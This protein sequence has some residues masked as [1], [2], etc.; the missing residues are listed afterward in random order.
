[1]LAS[2]LEYPPLEQAILP[3]DLVV[4]AVDSAAAGGAAMVAAVWRVL[5]RRGVPPQ[6]V[7]ILESRAA[8][9]AAPSD[10]RVELPPEARGRIAWKVHDPDREDDRVY[11][12]STAAG[13]RIYLNRTLVDADVV[14]SLGQIA[15]D[16]LIGVAGTNSVFYPGM[17][18]REAVQRAQG[19][20]HDELG[21]NEDRPLRQVMDEIGWLL[22]SQFTVQTIPAAGRGVSRVLA[23]SPESVLRR[24][25][26]LLAEHWLIELKS[27]PDIVIAAVDADAGGHGWE[28]AGA[29]LAVARNLVARGGQI[30]LLTE[31]AA[32]P[33]P[34][35][36]MLREV[37]HPRDALRP[38]QSSHPADLVPAMQFAAAADRAKIYFLSRLEP[39]LVDEL[40]MTPLDSAQQ[41]ERLL[42]GEETLAFLPSAQHMFG[43]IRK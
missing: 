28:Q 32:E 14:L 43:R 5:E 4:L 10:P 13:E 23:G 6:N 31:L 7:V 37:E 18:S 41:V 1:M 35:I 33:G 20:G 40:F 42:K 25:K 34:G 11:L 9:G 29:A 8:S 19:V 36:E 15:Y 27:R 17:S 21:P 3:D 39:N 22:G 30:I 38:L 16:P 2:P 24:G 26:R 12:A